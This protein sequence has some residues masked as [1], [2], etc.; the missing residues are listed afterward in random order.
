MF[1]H[2]SVS[3]SSTCAY[4]KKTHLKG[5]NKSSTDFYVDVNIRVSSWKPDQLPDIYS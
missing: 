1:Q 4:H 5:N 3:S 2:E